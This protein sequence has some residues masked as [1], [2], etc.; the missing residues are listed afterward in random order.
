MVA[1]RAHDRIRDVPRAAWNALV[2]DGSPFVEWDWLALLEDSGAAVPATGWLPR[3]L[4]AWDGD[5]LVAACPV[6]AKGH[7]LGEFVFDQSWAAAASRAGIAYYPKLLVAVPFTPVTGTRFLTAP[8]AD[9]AALVGALGG[10]LEELCGEAELSSV[11]ANF[12]L[13]DERAAL[14]ARGWLRRVGWQ[15]HWT[16][17]GYAAFDDYLAGLRSKRRNQVRRERRALDEAGIEIA[18]YTGDE[19]PD[20]LLDRMFDLYLTTIEKLPWGQQY[21]ERSFFRLAG[22]RMRRR[23]CLIIARR[24]GEVLAGTFNVRKGDAL[25]GRYW[26]AVAEVRHLHFNVCYYAAIEY[27]IAHRLARFEPGAGGEF[28]LLRGFDATPTESMH[29]IRDRRLADAVRRFLVQERR[30][31]AREIDWLGEKT[32]L[33]RDRGR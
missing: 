2:G 9:R 18:A 22:E 21:L 25:Y 12:C 19:I 20:G 27:C 11:H 26:G 14:E 10:A 5:R 8:G 28:K 3:H 32:A 31:V 4:T 17:P 29:W 13:D 16:N 24:D 15:Y 23:L 1:I 30:A 6:Y 7:S 33:R